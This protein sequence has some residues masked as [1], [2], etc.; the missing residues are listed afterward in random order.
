MYCTLRAAR[1]I[2]IL[3]F[4]TP[5]K[6]KFTRSTRNARGSERD[7]IEY[8]NFDVISS[9]ERNRSNIKKYIYT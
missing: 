8:P 7:R 1:D 5:S 3:K 9:D 2:R 4:E 6:T